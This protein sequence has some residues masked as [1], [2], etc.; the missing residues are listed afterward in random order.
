MARDLAIA[1]GGGVA[2]AAL[3]LA[4]LLN[5][6]GVLI[7]AYLA[8]MPMFVVGLGWGTNTAAVAAL[9][10]TA[11]IAGGASPTVGLVFAL[12]YAAPTA[13]MVHLALRSRLAPDGRTAWYPVGRLVSWLTV[14]ACGSFALLALITGDSGVQE[15]ARQI[16]TILGS[17][18]PIEQSPQ[19]AVLARAIAGYFPAIVIFC[20]LIMMLVNAV[21]AQIALE[22]VGRNLRP[23]P[24][25]SAIE[26]PSWFTTATVAGAAAALIAPALD[27]TALGFAARNTALAML[28]PFLLVGLSV[29]HVWARQWPAR[30]A[31]LIGVYALLLLFGWLAVLVAGLGFMEQW[32]FLRRKLGGGGQEDEQ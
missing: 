10:A 17:V 20:W 11:A 25:A 13:V 29:V 26:L 19:V 30:M 5:V 14:Y 12:V 18:L 32:L 24:Q 2:S 9:V 6:P 23:A 1:A 16:E 22:R 15:A 21:L 28:G 3:Y 8:L 31:I 4:T 27:L 7:L